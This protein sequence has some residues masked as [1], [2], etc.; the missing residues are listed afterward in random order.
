MIPYCV[1][2]ADCGSWMER[3]LP[4]LSFL[5]HFWSFSW[6]RRRIFCTQVSFFIIFSSGCNLKAL[7]S[8]YNVFVLCMLA[9][10][11]LIRQS[12][13]LFDCLSTY[14]Y[15]HC[16]P[17]IF[18]IEI[19]HCW[20]ECHRNQWYHVKL[21]TSLS[22]IDHCFIP[23]GH[24]LAVIIIGPIQCNFRAFENFWDTFRWV[25]GWDGNIQKFYGIP[26]ADFFDEWGKMW[27][28]LGYSF[29]PTTNIWIYANSNLLP[30]WIKLWLSLF[31]EE[32]WRT[33]PEF[34]A[35]LH[36]QMMKQCKLSAFTR[37]QSFVESQLTL[38]S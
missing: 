9:S 2:C 8:H 13:S 7:Y 11:C 31:Q 29:K 20:T 35:S 6:S 36:M 17:R 18:R 14:S 21:R 4:S 24:G 30:N 27:H 26:A 15:F 22:A 23:R 16:K 28:K 12:S 1:V 34:F 3:I 33:S 5:H 25:L 10:R 37:W 38:P 32:S 19:G